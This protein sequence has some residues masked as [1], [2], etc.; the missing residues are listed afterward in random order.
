M[1]ASK[2][3][4]APAPGTPA[5]EPTLTTADGTQDPATPHPAQH[6]AQGAQRHSHEGDAPQGCREGRDRGTKRG[7]LRDTG[8]WGPSLSGL[9]L[10]GHAGHARG[11]G[12]GGLPQGGHREAL[13]GNGE[14]S[15]GQRPHGFL[16]NGFPPFGNWDRAGKAELPASPGTEQG[17]TATP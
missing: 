2:A 14:D 9:G 15:G 1:E 10:L 8:D 5:K 16:S 4:P 12:E 17:G 7:S 3:T 13:W 6:G 11:H